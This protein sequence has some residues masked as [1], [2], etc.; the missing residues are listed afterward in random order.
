MRFLSR[1]D[2]GGSCGAGSPLRW[3]GHADL[4]IYLIDYNLVTTLLVD[5]SGDKMY[6]PTSFGGNMI[7]I[8]NK[9]IGD[10]AGDYL[11]DEDSDYIADSM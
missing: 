1:A 10:Q 11:K 8:V 3:L 7:E 5:Y 4:G 2:R 6:S 9:I